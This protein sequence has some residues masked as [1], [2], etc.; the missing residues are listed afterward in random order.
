MNPSGTSQ[1]EMSTEHQRQ[2]RQWVVCQLG[3]RE[4]YMMARALASSGSLAALITDAWEKPG[5][6]VTRLSSRL[7]ERYHPGLAGAR[8][9]APRYRTLAH[10]LR[11]RYLGNS[12]WR[13]IMD[14][15]VWFEEMAA[16]QLRALVGEGV[17]CD[18][19]FAYSYAAGGIL[20][21]A[22]SLGMR[23]VL[24]QIDPG[25]MEDEIVADLYARAGQSQRYERIPEAYWS[26]WREEIELS[27]VVVA[28]S[29]WSRMLLVRAGVPDE[30]I[31]I[32]PLAYDGLA[33]VTRRRR[34]VP[35]TF[36]AGRPLRLL[37]LGQVT[38][39]KG[40]G[41]LLAAFESMPH[42]PLRLDV[43]GPVQIDMPEASRRDP[44]IVMHGAVPRSAVHRHYDE[45][46]LFAFPTLS[47]G[48][49]LTQLEALAHGLP[50]LAS[51]NCGEVIE[52]EA[53]GYVLE[54]VTPEA[55]ES[56]LAGLLDD[57]RRLRAWT[58]RANG[59]PRFSPRALAANLQRLATIE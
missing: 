29:P 47:D 22:R 38:W 52:H 45:A 46:D 59:S 21:E 25:P 20:R 58:E 54:S 5:S 27:D 19:V 16:A 33:H 36:T 13:R 51:R 9:A 18:T 4:S 50:V 14:R 32:V 30:K 3:A 48:F 7:K 44:R 2:H 49:G 42:A 35:D 24:G 23:T 41:P 57:P 17:R 40:I 55:I 12:G 15:N 28:N 10:E 43:V 39:R 6:V 1:L 37:F 8:V 34:S 56:V 11:G 26:R 31:S 53:N